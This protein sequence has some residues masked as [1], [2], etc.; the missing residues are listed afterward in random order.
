MARRLRGID[1]VPIMKLQLIVLKK[2][3]PFFRRWFECHHDAMCREAGGV[4]DLYKMAEA[5]LTAGLA[6]L[7]DL[8]QFLP[9]RIVL[10]GQFDG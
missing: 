10:N 7:E 2:T 8:A 5:L 1:S 3:H 6:H 4:P 9:V